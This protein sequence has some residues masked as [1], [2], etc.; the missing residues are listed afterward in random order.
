MQ[1]IKTK[2][3]KMLMLQKKAAEAEKE[4]RRKL[5]ERLE[6]MASDVR[7]RRAVA[8]ESC[9]RTTMQIKDECF[10]GIL[11]NL[12]G[13]NC[14]KSYNEQK[15]ILRRIVEKRQAQQAHRKIGRT[16]DRFSGHIMRRCVSVSMNNI[17]RYQMCV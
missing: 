15:R 14:Q 17:R 12:Q 7:Y 3:E 6:T 2:A 1:R 16:D 10:D 5:A 11:V 4:R 8:K 13:D 9:K